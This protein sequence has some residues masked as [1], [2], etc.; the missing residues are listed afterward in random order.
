MLPSIVEMIKTEAKEITAT[1]VNQYV[2]LQE[3]QFALSNGIDFG[4]QNMKD[5]IEEYGKTWRTLPP[6]P[7][8]LKRKMNS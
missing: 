8:R 3:F 5:D 6:K 4:K 7:S 1:E 2:S